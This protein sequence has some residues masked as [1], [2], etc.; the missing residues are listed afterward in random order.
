MKHFVSTCTLFFVLVGYA[1]AQEAPVAITLEQRLEHLV[2]KLE[3]KRVEHHIP[4]MSL[5][6]VLD[7]ETVLVHSFGH[8][9]IEIGQPVTDNSLFSIGSVTKSF[10]AA[11]VAALVDDGTMQWDAPI[12]DYLPAFVLPVEPTE[13]E[14]NDSDVLIRDL[15]SHQTGFTRMHFL[16]VNNALSPEETLRTA[17]IAEPWGVFRSEFLYNNVQYLAAGYAA[18]K[19]AG[20]DW[21]TLVEERLFSPIGMDSTYTSW[22]RAPKDQQVIMG[23]QWEEDTEEYDAFQL[24]TI[25]NIGPAGSIISTASDMARWVRFHLN[26][27]EIDGKQ[28]IT[29]EQHAELW[30]S[31]FE[32]APGISYGFGWML[33]EQEG[34]Y[35]VE[36]G[37]NVHGGSALLTMYPDENLGFVLLMN[38]S[39]SPLQ[40][41]SASIVRSSMLGDISSDGVAAIDLT[42]YLGK[43]VGDFASFNGDIFTVQ[44]KNGVLAVDVPGQMLYELKPPD[45]EDKW[46]FAITDQVAI[47]F[48]KDDEGRVVGMRFHQAGMTF[49]LPREGVEIEPDIPLVELERY[50]G[51]YHCISSDT[52]AIFII[53]NNRLAADWPKQ[54]V[55]ELFP[56]TEEGDWVF[57]VTDTIRLRFTEDDQR[58]VTGF[59]YAQGDTTLLFG[60]VDDANKE[61]LPTVDSILAAYNLETREESLD[62]LGCFKFQGKAEMMQSGVTGQV[63]VWVDNNRRLRSVT[64][65]GEFGWLRFGVVGDEGL[66]DLS[67][68]EP[69]ELDT[70]MIKNI[71]AS[72]PLAWVGNWQDEYESITLLKE[73]SVDDRQV[74]IFKLQHEDDPSKTVTIDRQTGDVLRVASK[75]PVPEI[76]GSL[77]YSIV[78]RDYKEVGGVRIPMTITTRN[79]MT[80]DSV[81]GFTGVETNVDAPDELF[82]V[83]PRERPEPWIARSTTD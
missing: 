6:V 22:H 43:F 58:R 70:N 11:A 47:S 80:G 8:S 78:Y 72:S 64:D 17:I 30:K 68:V 24:R 79:D 45:E 67:F 81:V 52:T 39:A 18:G 9:N 42:P 66:M 54:M 36:H 82:Q 77:P 14:P 20:S 60:R 35:V 4:G 46:Y 19:V 2:E 65:C 25:D 41:E 7:D 13:D 56:P 12:T 3:A 75:Q 21:N 28:I 73:D 63:E 1:K 40:Q 15:L 53:K 33:H 50:L 10:T 34:A 74:W 44:D 32:I 48:E 23:Y 31:Q 76:G 49:E 37:G 26:R 27:G 61:A 62:S 55:Y 59:V 16:A 71:H 83:I 57:R 5:A 38:V 29:S 69:D 51:A